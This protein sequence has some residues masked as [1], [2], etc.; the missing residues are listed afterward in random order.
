[1]SIQTDIWSLGCIC[2][3]MGTGDHAFKAENIQQIRKLVENEQVWFIH[4]SIPA[5]YRNIR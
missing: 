2:F 4:I 3:E 5:K 1:M